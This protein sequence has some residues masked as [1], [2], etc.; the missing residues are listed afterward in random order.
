MVFLALWAVMEERDLVRSFRSGFGAQPAAIVRA[1]GRVN[2]IGD[3][4]D[5]L[6][7]PV[8]PMAV[9]RTI[10]IALRPRRDG[11]VRAANTDARFAPAEFPAAAEIPASAAGSWDNY[12]KAGVGSA[13]AAAGRS[14]GVGFDA[15]VDSDLPAAAGLSSSSALVVAAALAALYAAG[16]PW[17]RLALA[18]TLARGERYVGTEGGGM[19]QAVCL[20]A[21]AG[22][23]LRIDFAPLRVQPVAYPAGWRLLVAPSLRE[24]R[25]SA[26][27][28]AAYNER[29]RAARG[30]LAAAAPG[31]TAPQLVAL[32]ERDPAA[33]AG[34][35]RGQPRLRHVLSEC[36]R[37]LAAV[38]LLAAGDAAGLGR[39]MTESHAS[40]RDDYQVSTP[41]LDRLVALALAA[42]ALGARL[43][44]AGFGGC[45]IALCTAESAPGVRAALAAGF[46]A[47]AGEGSAAAMFVASPSAGAA[48]EPLG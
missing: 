43:T 5:Y 27:L 48:V 47:G 2:L 17:D 46:Y 16:E 36:R 18:E 15:L 44:G 4:I 12:L 3:H 39:L 14:A 7:L 38:P 8:L 37:A 26:G 40:L 1:P 31:L 34:V 32:L 20:C 22:H 9:Q 21:L 10:R 45:A 23:A 19:D 25:K 35:A 30:A 24:S 41:E 42:G 13:L 6:G 11:L 29:S 28:R 33:L